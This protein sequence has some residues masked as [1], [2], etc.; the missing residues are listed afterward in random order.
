MMSEPL[1][2]HRLEGDNVDAVISSD[3]LDD[4]RGQF[5]IVAGLAAAPGQAPD[6]ALAFLV[7][8]ERQPQ[9][10][11]RLVER[12]RQGEVAARR[13]QVDPSPDRDRWKPVPLDHDPLPHHRLEPGEADKRRI[14]IGSEPVERIAQIAGGRPGMI[15]A[16]DTVA[17]AEDFGRRV[18]GVTPRAGCLQIASADIARLEIAEDGQR[19]VVR[20]RI[21]DLDRR[22]GSL[23][24]AIRSA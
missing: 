16:A 10:R 1:P 13:A 4:R 2:V 21:G 6:E 5:R 19:R 17:K 8:F 22:R 11:E 14:G 3:P 7:L 15:D 9:R 18:G 12:A 24:N 23:E 20:G